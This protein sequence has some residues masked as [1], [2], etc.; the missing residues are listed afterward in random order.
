MKKLQG[1]KA[2]DADLTLIGSDNYLKL[3][4][5]QKLQERL[6]AANQMGVR[7]NQRWCTKRKC[8]KQQLRLFC[9]IYRDEYRYQAA[10]TF[11]LMYKPT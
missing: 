9:I 2:E 3:S 11:S 4:L 6:L 1:V 5:K 8:K 10:Y 7:E